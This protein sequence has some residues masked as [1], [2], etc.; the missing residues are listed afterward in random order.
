GSC[1]TTSSCR[2][3]EGSGGRATAVYAGLSPARGCE[4]A[5]LDFHETDLEAAA[6]RV[7]AAGQREAV[8]VPL[9]FTQGYHLRVDV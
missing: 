9:L 5:Y 1:S 8:V 3:A 4:A 6:Q 7:A 2:G